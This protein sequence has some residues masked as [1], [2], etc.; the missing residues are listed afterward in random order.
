MNRNYRY[1]EKEQQES[2][3]YDYG[4]RHYMPDL[5]RW[6]G[7][8][9]LSESYASFSPYAYVMNNPMSFVDPDGRLA[10]QA[11]DTILSSESG[12]TW[13]NTGLGFTSTGL[14]SMDYDGNR[15][16]WSNEYS[17]GLLAKLGVLP[18][19]LQSVKVINGNLSYF[20]HWSGGFYTSTG[21]DLGIGN[22]KML[23]LS[24]INDRISGFGFANGVKTELIQRAGKMGE[25]APATKGY[26]KFFKGMGWI[27]GGA[28]LAYS[29]DD[30]IQNGAN[31]SNTLDLIMG[32]VS[33]VPGYGWAV[34]GA[35]FLLN[36]GIE[37]K[38]GQNIGQHIESWTF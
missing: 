24:A 36:A 3:M 34:S 13:F 29:V 10:Q 25:L 17:S 23:K 6:F 32:G 1:N 20:S 11:I 7:M 16:N 31:V 9:K 12:T 4:W 18:G 30:M 28:N 26:L 38:T 19:T 35:Y 14:N 21:M 33:F 15:I 27:A 5:G 2:G 37:Q 22:Y 8:D